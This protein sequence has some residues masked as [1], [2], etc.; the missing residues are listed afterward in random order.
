MARDPSRKQINMTVTKELFDQIKDTCT[1]LDV[2]CSVWVRELIK[3][4]LA[5]PSLPIRPPCT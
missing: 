1:Q 4:E 2:P 5:Q 3:R